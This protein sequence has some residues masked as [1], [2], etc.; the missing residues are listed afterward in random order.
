MKRSK[1]ATK[2][3]GVSSHI[4]S[5]SARMQARFSL[6]NL[7]LKMLCAA[8]FLSFS[9][10]TFA[11]DLPDFEGLVRDQGRAVVKVT[12][13]ATETPENETGS[14]PNF[15]EEELPEF[16]QRF[17]EDLPDTPGAPPSAV[18]TAGFGSGFV[19]SEDGYVVTN[20]HVVRN[21][22]EITLELPD[23]REFDAE[24]VGSDERSDV[25]L[26]KVNATGLPTLAL[27]DSDSL[28]VGQWVLAI[29]SPFGFEYT[30]TQGIVSALSRSLPTEENYVPFI[31]TDVAVNPGN[32]GGPLFDLNGNVIGV[33]SQI[34]SRSGGYMG[35]SFAIPI[36][37]VQSVATQLRD[38][39]YVSRGWLGVLIQDIDRSLAESFGLDRPAGAL[40]AQVTEGSPAADAGV[41]V[42]DV[43]L[44]F[45]GNDISQ[46]S[47]LPPL[48]GNTPV[49]EVTSMELIRNK[50]RMTLEVIIRE[51]E[52]ERSA[53]SDPADNKQPTLGMTAIPLNAEQKAVL[54]VDNGLLIGEV[55]SNGPAALAGITKG[56][57]LI[58]FDQVSVT[59][60]TQLRQLVDAAEKGK[61]VA[62]L[63]HRKKKPVFA[64]LT[65]PR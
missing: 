62:V 53:Q 32:S 65:I 27:G 38:Q 7:S 46:S 35:L 56:D 59:S 47:D 9:M 16:F 63:I 5:A 41:I 64:A 43:I 22:S 15:N 55:A 1:L 4:A 25:A 8:L 57:V 54:E 30:A 40:I 21:A 37:V 45:N 18:P 33:N 12:V 10:K 17:F 34:F 19:L 48:V 13:S 3:T 36:N 50:E 11:I 28:K 60:N 31:Q 58:S 23:G 14:L 51:L 2:K 20:A 26:L 39:G 29:G 24:V 6:L 42:G 52:E 44:S 49:G 61:S